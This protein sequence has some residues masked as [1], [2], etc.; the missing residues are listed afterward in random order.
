MD[1]TKQF[2]VN[3]LEQELPLALSKVRESDSI[4]RARSG[5]LVVI[6]GLMEDINQRL[7][8]GTPGLSEI[9]LFGNLFKHHKNSSR[10]SELV[11]LLRPVVVAHRHDWERDLQ[12]LQERIQGMRQSDSEF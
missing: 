5:Q 10:K 9:P 11:I 2:T 7:Q 6:G 3:G 12:N 4:V 8:A 1:Q